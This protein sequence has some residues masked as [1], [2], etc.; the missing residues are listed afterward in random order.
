MK[1]IPYMTIFTICCHY[2]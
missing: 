1:L 2:K